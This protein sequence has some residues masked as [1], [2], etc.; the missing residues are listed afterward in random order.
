MRGDVD[1]ERRRFIFVADLSILPVGEGDLLLDRDLLLEWERERGSTARLGMDLFDRDFDFDLDL[2]LDLDFDADLDLDLD[3][4]FDRERLRD[5]AAISLVRRISPNTLP[6]PTCASCRLN[7]PRFDF[8]L[9]PPVK[10]GSPSL[11]PT[12]RPPKAAP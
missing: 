6:R 12:P 5:L 4:D 10:K 9:A 3:L 8:F 11:V 1:L 2:D 7:F